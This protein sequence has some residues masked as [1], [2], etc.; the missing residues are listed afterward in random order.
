MRPRAAAVEEAGVRVFH[1]YPPALHGGDT[2][3]DA[4]IL[5][6]V[7]GAASEARGQFSIRALGAFAR[8]VPVNT[9]SGHAV[10]VVRDATKLRVVEAERPLPLA[11]PCWPP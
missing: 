2:E 7:W 8:Y 3:H 1:A 10:L 11:A 9:Q 6:L 4:V 5:A